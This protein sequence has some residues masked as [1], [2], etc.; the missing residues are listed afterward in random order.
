MKIRSQLLIPVG[1]QLAALSVIPVLVVW[2]VHTS[3]VSL[4]QRASLGQA[5][6]AV[7][8][9]QQMAAEYFHTPRPSPQ[10][11][12]Q[13]AAAV[14][15]LTRSL[16]G[17]ESA[18]Q[19][20]VSGLLQR[21]GEKKQRNLAIEKE[22]FGLTDV[23]KSQSDAYVQQTVAKL[24]DR[25]RRDAV[26]DLERLVI[27]GAHTNTAAQWAIQALLNRLAYDLGAKQDLLTFLDKANT[28][29]A[30]DI[31]RL[32]NTPFLPM[33][34]AARD[35]NQKLTARVQE[36]IANMENI[37]EA[38]AACQR[39]WDHLG[40]E[41]HAR[42]QQSQASAGNRVTAG[43]VLV[44]VVT[45]VTGLLTAALILVLGLRISRSLRNT[46]GRL[47]DICEGEGDL[48]KRLS[49]TGHDEFGELAT[50]FNTFVAKLERVIA[51][52][53][54]GTGSLAGAAASLSGTASNL[55]GGADQATGQS[56][57]VAAAAEQMSTN[58]HGMAAAT[59]QMS[60]N[61][62]VVASSVD[63]LT[64][65]I[66]EVARSAEQAASVAQNATRLAA[67]SNAR[68]TELGTAADEIGKVIQVIEDIAEQTNLLALNATIEAARAGEAGKGFAV[69]ATE[70]KELARQTAGATEDIRRRI[71]GI[72]GSTGQAVRSIGDI[73]A[74]IEQVNDLSRTIASAV[75]EQSITT[76]EIAR[77][78]SQSSTAAETV[79][80]G[81]AESASASQEITQNIVGV[82][83]AAKQTAQ[84]AA[85]TQ[86]AGQDL[87]RL[88]EQLQSLVA[89]FRVGDDLALANNSQ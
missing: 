83:Q 5:A 25:A 1:A 37:A 9:A 36:Y 19:V 12:K 10:L 20:T 16:D 29:V 38:R 32:Q 2:S 79:A 8:R 3:R 42:V 89:Q 11:E 56:A 26:T 87:S 14:A 15:D 21:A 80:R 53:A 69:V 77:N 64:A 47:R 35:A 70:V 39:Q 33:A 28:N 18:P 73:G 30:E 41:L 62:Q 72:Q 68:I 82:D 43:F 51:Q 27:V 84:G 63:E 58:M 13:L 86:A 46:V 50:W 17:L 23:S 75:E 24:A 66:C 61:V 48:T 76:K 65:S 7:D 55:A 54:S 44:G 4:E 67:D 57:Q 31:K 6:E 40:T 74:V 52:I 45:A 78:V 59:R 85:H 71:E 88:A 81:V 60:A 49:V 34:D 22:M